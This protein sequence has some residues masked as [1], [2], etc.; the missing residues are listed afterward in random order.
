MERFISK[1]LYILPTSHFRLIQLFCLFIFVSGL[2][3]FG[4]G[5]IGPFLTLANKPNLIHEKTGINLIYDQLNFQDESFFIATLGFLAITIFLIKSFLSWQLKT[6]VFKYSF[7]QGGL[8]SKKLLSNYLDAPY[9]F[10]L[11]KSSVSIIQ[12]LTNDVKAFSNSIL[13]PL[14]EL[15]SNLVIIVT[16]T[17]LLCLTNLIAVVAILSLTLP[18]VLVFQR[19]SGEL[20]KWGK[21][22]SLSNQ[23]IIRVINHSLGGIKETKIIGCKDYFESQLDQQIKQYV[24]ATTSFFGFK[25][26]PRILTELLLFIFLIGFISVYLL[27]KQDIKELIPILGVFTLTSLRIV[28]ALSNSTGQIS[29]LRNSSYILDRLYFDLKELETV[30]TEN[31]SQR[32]VLSR[33]VSTHNYREATPLIHEIV[34][35]AVSYYYPHSTEAAIEHVSL[36][37]EKGQSIALIGK[38]GAGKTTLVDIILG[39]LVP[40]TGDIRVNNQ[41]IYDDLRSWQNTIGYIPQS[42]FLIEDTIEKNIAFGVPEHLIDSHRLQKA[43]QAAQL[44]ELVSRLPDGVKTEVGERGVRL[45][46]GQRQRIGI[47]RA[48]YHEREV[49]VLD[50]ATSALDNETEGLVTESIKSLS[51]TKTM[52]IIA[53]RLTTVE[54]CDCI[55]LM[56][57][58]RIVK[59]GTYQ[60]VVLKENL[61]HQ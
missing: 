29:T 58:G 59:S 49:L 26:F 30:K 48:L 38:S 42:I 4:L 54:H 52:I 9:L 12:T 57:Q 14:L 10:H 23:G 60:E 36:K 50:E 28:P 25:L 17:L 46:G 41:T 22:I 55:Y 39:L 19:F 1:F 44:E 6:F 53:H 24:N 40:Q 27:F 8:L 43:I 2:E 16:L 13:L 31:Q 21:S 34:L 56:D 18:L 33:L 20:K 15:C 61:L 5:I 11:S 7:E 51:G 35:D 47:A 37:I 32:T 3:F 45:S